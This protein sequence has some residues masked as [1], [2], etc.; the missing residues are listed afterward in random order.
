M[1]L[2]HYLSKQAGKEDILYETNLPRLYTIMTGPLSPN[3]TELIGSQL[4]IDLLNHLRE[5]FDVVIIDSPP[6]GAVIDAAVMAPYCDGAVL[7]I[8]SQV[9]S[10]RLIADVKK[11]LEVTGCKILGT[12]LNKVDM[13]DRRYYTKYYKEYKQEK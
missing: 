5:S 2:S 13:S 10:R 12:V 7:V 8:E 3:P 1:G 9:T 4:F 6:L 11:Q